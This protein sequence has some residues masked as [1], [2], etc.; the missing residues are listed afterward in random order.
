MT[1]TTDDQPE[2]AK[3]SERGARGEPAAHPGSASLQDKAAINAGFSRDKVAGLDLGASPLGTDD[4]AGATS[5]VV[6]PTASRSPA[7]KPEGAAARDP[8]RANAVKPPAPWLWILAA[9]AAAL[10]LG[11]ALLAALG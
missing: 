2:Q 3:A 7:A 1:Y 5:T 10:V 8:D 9:V 4:E 6:E 11:Y